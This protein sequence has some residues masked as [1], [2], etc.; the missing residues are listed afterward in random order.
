[1]SVLGVKDRMSEKRWKSGDIQ[2]KNKAREEEI[3]ERRGASILQIIHCWKLM[4]EINETLTPAV[5]ANLGPVATDEYLCD[6]N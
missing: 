4:L 1:M 2:K 6:L 5:S 3:G